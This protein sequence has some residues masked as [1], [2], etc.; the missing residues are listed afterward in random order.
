MPSSLTS[1]GASALAGAVLALL[2]VTST[3][4]AASFAGGTTQVTFSKSAMS[5][6]KRAGIKITAKA[7]AKVAGARLTLPVTSGSA[8]LVRKSTGVLRHDGVIT[9][10]GKGRSMVMTKLAEVLAGSKATLTAGVKGKTVRLFAQSGTTFA[11]PGDTGLKGTRLKATLTSQGAAAMNKAF[12]VKAFRTGASIGTVSFSADRKIVFAPG[13]GNSNFK[14]DPNTA[15]AFQGCGMSVQPIA[16]ASGLP[17]GPDAPA[18]TFVFPINGGSLNARTLKGTVAH[19][20]G[21]S[22][23]KPGSQSVAMTEFAFE[24][25]AAGAPTFT[26]AADVLQG[27]RAT[28]GDV[29]G[30]APTLSLTPTGG[31]VTFKG[32]EVRWSG[33]AVALLDAF[34]QCKAVPQGSL[35]GVVDAT[36]TVK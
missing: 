33:A 21:V 2:L 14:F 1:R 20:G 27:N 9:L 6:L 19:V 16:P 28:I 22:I 18:G 25:P 5:A 3:A 11:T 29:T 32:T 36:A 35:I 23:S 26:T 15:G 12:K 34:Y 31:T 8:S 17:P 4:G 30:P 13:A 24:Y 10:K 7:P